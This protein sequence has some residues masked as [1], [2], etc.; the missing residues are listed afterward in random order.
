LKKDLFSINTPVEV[1]DAIMHG[2]DMWE[3]SQS[4]QQLPVHALT[5]GSLKGSHVLL[6]A[7]FTN[8]FHS[9]GWQ[10]LLK[11]RMSHQ[12]GAA[13]ASF[14]NKPND[15]TSNTMWTAQ[16]IA[17]FWK[18]LRSE[19]AY[20]N[21]VVHGSNDKEIAA[22]IKKA[23]T[24]KVKEYYHTFR[25]TPNFILSRH[26][27]LFT[28]RTL[29]QRLK[30][31]IDSLNCWIRSVEDAI[32][33]L[34]HHNNQQRLHSA[35]FFA[36]FFVAGRRP[37]TLATQDSSDSDY[38][39]SLTQTDDHTM[40]TF[41]SSTFQS[42]TTDTISLSSSQVTNTTR[43]SEI[44]TSSSSNGPPSIISWSIS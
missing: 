11:G 41:T 9:I 21:T 26:Q 16:A 42:T 5:A 19:W 12:W 39:A 23:S 33:A 28:S 7:A 36:P 24:D 34:Q 32:Q 14:R 17:I 38:S 37:N 2:M 31:D 1:I 25:T 30:L 29:D 6:T 44:D 43:S 13:V 10:H 35:R 8:Q 40:T 20:R 18:Y 15:T 27:Y 3:C 4:T 22:Q